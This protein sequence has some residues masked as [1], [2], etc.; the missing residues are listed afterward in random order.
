VWVRPSILAGL[1]VLA[2]G[3]V[4]PAWVQNA[5][6]VQAWNTFVHYAN[7]HF[8]PEP[9]GFYGYNALQQLA[10]FATIFIMAPLSILTGMAMSPALVNRLP[11]DFLGHPVPS[12]RTSGV[13]SVDLRLGLTT[14]ATP[15]FP[16]I[17]RFVKGW[18]PAAARRRSAPKLCARSPATCLRR[19]TPWRL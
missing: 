6:F 7:F 11:A 9:N 2:L 8:P 16:A 3:P 19:V 5:V 10:Y 4:V 13:L 17:V 15:S 12:R 1:L 18:H 14:R